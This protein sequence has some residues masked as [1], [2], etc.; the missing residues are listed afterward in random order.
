MKSLRISTLSYEML[1]DLAKRN[2]PSSKPEAFLQKM[3]EDLHRK[4]KR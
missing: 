1:V 2:K 3:I 4:I